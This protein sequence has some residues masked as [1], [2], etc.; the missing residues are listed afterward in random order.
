MRWQSLQQV[1]SVN[2][3]YSKNCHTMLAHHLVVHITKHLSECEWHTPHA[4]RL[5][6]HFCTLMRMAVVHNILKCDASGVVIVAVVLS[7][8]WMWCLIVV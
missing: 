2:A 6:I 3:K 5:A 1:L 8:L 7:I 4:H